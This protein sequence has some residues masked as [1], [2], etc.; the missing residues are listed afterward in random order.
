[1]CTTKKIQNNQNNSDMEAIE[2]PIC[3]DVAYEAF[4]RVVR[5]R[6]VVYMS[7]KA[8]AMKYVKKYLSKYDLTI[9][10]KI[11]LNI[12]LSFLNKIQLQ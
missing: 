7:D 2:K 9:H 12:I 1:M 10:Q 4:L 8:K 11:Q 3:N 6:I 5:K